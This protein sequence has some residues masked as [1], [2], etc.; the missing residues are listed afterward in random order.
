[1]KMKGQEG[2]QIQMAYCDHQ[3]NSCTLIDHE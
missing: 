1:M 2:K 3:I